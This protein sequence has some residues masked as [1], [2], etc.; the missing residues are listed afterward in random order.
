MFNMLVVVM[1][2][3]IIIIFCPSPLTLHNWE[4]RLQWMKQPTLGHMMVLSGELEQEATCLHSFIMLDI[5]VSSIL[6]CQI[7]MICKG[8]SLRLIK[9]R[10]KE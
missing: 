1:M 10:T 9:A 2:T 6:L 5:V 4:L 3:I 7:R 8:K